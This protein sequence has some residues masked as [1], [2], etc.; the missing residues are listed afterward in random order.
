MCQ[1][2][3][4]FHPHNLVTAFFLFFFQSNTSWQRDCLTGMLKVYFLRVLL[5][6]EEICSSNQEIPIVG[7]RGDFVVMNL[8]F[9]NGL[10]FFQ[11]RAL[12]LSSM[13]IFYDVIFFF[14]QP[15]DLSPTHRYNLRSRGNSPADF[16]GNSFLNNLPSP[17]KLQELMDN[18]QQGSGKR[19][20][21]V[22][23]KPKKNNSDNTAL[24]SSDEES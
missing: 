3:Y 24:F 11:P 15:Q 8:N 10:F 1:K 12:D 2:L 7:T 23:R 4:C 6:R 16:N 9:G 17:S 19:Y 20:T 5:N 13:N 18:L 22:I 21:A 14:F